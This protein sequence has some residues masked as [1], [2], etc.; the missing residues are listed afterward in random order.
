[1]K[2]NTFQ[3][4]SLANLQDCEVQSKN[5]NMEIM[6]AIK[7][8]HNYGISSKANSKLLNQNEIDLRQTIKEIVLDYPN[9]YLQKL[10]NEKSCL[11]FM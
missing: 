8:L 2:N 9:T 3:K 4:I 1:M 11:N 10:E 5:N 7:N 6:P